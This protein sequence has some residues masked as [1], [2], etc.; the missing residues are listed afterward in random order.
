MSPGAGSTGVSLAVVAA[1]RGC[2]CRISMP[3]DAAAEKAQL[4]RALGADVHRVR[5]VSITHPD[6]FV[7]VARRVGFPPSPFRADGSASVVPPLKCFRWC[8]NPLRRGSSHLCSGARRTG[9]TLT[10]T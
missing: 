9:R 3:D 2:R 10:Y 1:G 5:P 6:H 7:N 8:T 4:L